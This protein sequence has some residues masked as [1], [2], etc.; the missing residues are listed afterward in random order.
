MD[1]LRVEA[2]VGDR[3]LEQWR[4]VHNVIVPPDELSADEVR[5]RS[6][7]HRLENAYVGDELV[8]C[9][10]VRP[11]DGEEAVATVIARVLPEHR[12]RGFGGVLYEHCL[13]HAR[14]LG[15]QGIQTV[16]LAANADGVRFAEVRGFVEVE[17]YVAP[18]DENEV[19][20]T[21]RL[22]A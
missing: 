14:G 8:G 7:R 17:R 6:G 9:S 20:L 10:T 2:A 21:L 18:E 3:M 12:G 22:E 5:E 11:P 4:Y 13:A 15:A 19:W 16:V 1:D